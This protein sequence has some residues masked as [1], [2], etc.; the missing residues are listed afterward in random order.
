[1]RERESVGEHVGLI[2]K[3]ECPFV[4]EI[5]VQQVRGCLSPKNE[6]LYD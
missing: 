1:M 5:R 2:E 6:S 3:G 4:F